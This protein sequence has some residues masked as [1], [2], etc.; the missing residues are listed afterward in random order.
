M[1]PF[2][3][4]NVNHLKYQDA[5]EKFGWNSPIAATNDTSKTFSTE[6]GLFQRVNM[7]L[8]ALSVF[9][10][11]PQILAHNYKLRIYLSQFKIRF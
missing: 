3:C 9:F 4:K 10:F 11:L 6:Q 5:I 2:I 7:Y 8:S 1:W